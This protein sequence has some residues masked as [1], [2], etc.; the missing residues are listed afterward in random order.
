[1]LEKKCMY[2][3]DVVYIQEMVMLLQ[4]KAEIACVLKIR[5]SLEYVNYIT[6]YYRYASRVK[7]ITNDASKN[8]ENKEINRLKNASRF[9]PLFQSLNTCTC[10]ILY[11]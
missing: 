2:S 1:M 3:L 9:S 10:I 8:A 5:C 7:L 11:Y 6:V 4:L